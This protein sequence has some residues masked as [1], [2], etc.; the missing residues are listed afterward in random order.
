M[1]STPRGTVAAVAALAAALA[2]LGCGS[3]SVGD[4]SVPATPAQVLTDSLGEID[5]GNFRFAVSF[6]GGGTEG[7]VHRPSKSAA[8][9]MRFDVEGVKATL[10]LVH[11]EPETWLKW[12]L[13]EAAETRDLKAIDGRWLHLDPARIE[14]SGFGDLGAGSDP[15]G[16]AGVVAAT[17]DVVEAGDSM[18]TGVVDLAAAAETALVDEDLVKA[19]GDKAKALPFIATVDGRR[20]LSTLLVDVPPFGKVPASKLEFRYFDYGAVTP[21][22]KPGSTVPEAPASA[23]ELLNS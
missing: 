10:D 19:L 13:G 20:R 7:A 1:R 14:D 6:A 11:V 21:L 22:E 9:L 5:D 18:Y 4:D 16:V 23:Y 17:R 2:L 15:A 12:N 3:S 8:V